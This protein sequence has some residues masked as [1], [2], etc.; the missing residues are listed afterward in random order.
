MYPTL[1]CC[2]RACSVPR[3]SCLGAMLAF[4]HCQRTCS[5]SRL[6]YKHFPQLLLIFLF[7]FSFIDSWAG[8]RWKFLICSHV[9]QTS[10]EIF[11]TLSLFISRNVLFLKQLTLTGRHLLSYSFTEKGQREK[12]K[13]ITAN[14]TYRLRLVDFL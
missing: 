5:V 11:W 2:Q 14:F 6:V 4:T 3:Q 7:C 13:I 10:S 9:F 8:W 12:I 1:L